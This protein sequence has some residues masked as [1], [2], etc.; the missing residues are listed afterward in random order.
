MNKDYARAIVATAEKF[1]LEL[2][3]DQEAFELT[4][5]LNMIRAADSAGAQAMERAEEFQG[6]LQE[7][8][9]MLGRLGAFL[10]MGDFFKG[11]RAAMG[12]SR[13][14]RAMLL[15]EIQDESSKIHLVVM[16][17]A[18]LDVGLHIYPESLA[19]KI[20]K[21]LFRLQDIQLGHQQLDPLVMVKARDQRAATRRLS[22]TA[23]QNALLAL[24]EE[25][26]GGTVCNDISVRACLGGSASAE[27]LGTWLERLTDLAVALQA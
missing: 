20:G 6:R 27:Q 21:F 4:E 8:K 24:Y 1:G 9:D 13:G 19:G 12:S 15:P 25:G 7:K 2:R 22:G 5:S 14:C 17:S 26:E 23:V 3:E 11:H 18:P 16:M 10:P